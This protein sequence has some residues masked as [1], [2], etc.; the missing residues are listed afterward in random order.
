MTRSKRWGL[1]IA[2]LLLALAVLFPPYEV[3]GPDGPT[4]T[5]HWI[6]SPPASRMRR[7]ER[8]PAVVDTSG[9]QGSWGGP[10]SSEDGGPLTPTR[11]SEAAVRDA[12]AATESSRRLG[13]TWLLT[14]LAAGALVLGLLLSSMEPLRPG[15][16]RRE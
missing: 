13:G 5:W 6:G 10:S 16:Q 7:V 9:L 8:A 12:G 14:I 2:A 3:P 15:T 4:T 11:S 1:G